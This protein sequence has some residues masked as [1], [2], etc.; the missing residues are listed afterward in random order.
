VS[1]A[2][3]ARHY[4]PRGPSGF[5]TECADIPVRAEGAT[6]EEAVKNLRA[7]IQAYLERDENPF[8]D[9]VL[10]TEEAELA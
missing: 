2:D 6:R 5:V 8:A 10:I 7:A 3:A 9:Y 1:T 4:S